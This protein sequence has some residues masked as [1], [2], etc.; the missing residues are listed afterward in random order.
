MAFP[1][2][3]MREL[4]SKND[5]VSV[6]SESVQLTP[7]GSRLWGH[8][9]FHADR[10]P[11]FSVSPD[12]QLF[13]CF[14][15]KA[16]G[17]VIQFVMQSE[18]LS[19]ADAVRRLAQRAGM[20]MPEEID[21]S[22]LLAQKHRR[23]RIYEANREAALYYNSLLF[24]KE[25]GAAQRYLDARGVTAET[26][27]RFGLGF[28]PDGFDKLSRHLIEKG[29]SE[30]TLIDAGL[31]VKGRKDPSKIYDFFRGRLMFPVINAMGKV[32][33][34]GGRTMGHD[35]PKYINTG[36]TPV[37]NKRENIYAINLLKGKKL[38]DIIMVEGYM[39]VISLHQR[40]I[41]NAVASLGTALT[42]QQAR[43]I[44]R[45]ASKVYYAYDGDEAGQ[46]AMLRGIDILRSS[47]IEPRVI[48][49]PGGRDP[50]E[51]IKEF[52][53]DEFLTLKDASIT[54][55]RFKIER[56]AA[57]HGLD[58]PDGRERFAR[59][60]CRLLSGFDPVERDRYIPLVAEKS[61]LSPATVREQCG[62][63]SASASVSSKPHTGYASYRPPKQDTERLG[64]EKKLLAC[65]MT[66]PEAGLNTAKLNG[67]S[68][69]LFSSEQLRTFALKLLAAYRTGGSPDISLMIAELEPAEAEEA[70]AAYQE[71]GDIA[72]P[73]RAAADIIKCI[74]IAELKTKLTELS[75]GLSECRD[76]AQKKELTWEYRE[77]FS[78]LQA[79]IK[80]RKQ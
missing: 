36:D 71:S 8:C 16:G 15:C 34:F 65:M 26:A 28:S 42:N 76:E 24:S 27:K 57:E 33:A 67:F 51:F 5:I 77:C 18:N 46:K 61:G 55:V 48:V 31:A 60:A 44:K 25:G 14:S 38:D 37:Y 53:P 29:F 62:S 72:S 40:G 64:F 19:F 20:D 68:P 3:W 56:L 6:I 43:L 17:S 58:T 49:I 12:K 59:E 4:M 70:A 21:D 47:E 7:K 69:M 39:D 2:A 41:D 23:E 80:G 52:G 1:E 78:E 11:S 13:H 74:R 22:R 79:L 54:G 73:M 9:P 32:I 45:Y 50:D 35:E 30:S 75:Q 66:S 10:S 63:A